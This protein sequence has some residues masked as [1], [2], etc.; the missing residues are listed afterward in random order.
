MTRRQENHLLSLVQSF[1]VD[2]LQRICGASPHTV[3]AY[4]DTLRLLFIFLAQTKGRSVADLQLDDLHVDAVMAFLTQLEAKRRNTAATRNY[5]LAAIK[6]FCKHLIRHDLVHAEQYHRVLALPAKRA[7]PALAF[8]LEPEDVRRILAKPDRATALGVRD[9]ALLLFCYNTGA[10]VSEVL[11]V[12][13]EDLHLTK[14]RQVLLHG[15]GKK[16]RIVPLWRET[17]SALQRLESVRDARAGDPLFVNIRGESLTRDGVAHILRKY[18]AMALR[19]MP[20]LGRRTVTPHVLRHSC[21]AALLQAGTD[22]S[23][24]RDYLGHASIATTSRYITTNLQM[25]RDAL[26][27]FWRRAGI[28]P[29]H[30]KPWKPKPNLLAFLASL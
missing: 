18:V 30:T 4:R 21:A 12:R 15:K 19:D 2:H 3:R 28:A 26:E 16:D 5:R 22:I 13:V 8:Y 10:R 24:I 11:D 29:R 23:V 1:F 6:S 17:T 27:A 20:A 9:Y 14:P 7:K 25:K